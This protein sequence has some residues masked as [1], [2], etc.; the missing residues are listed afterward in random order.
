MPQPTA[1][2]SAQPDEKR[3]K[4]GGRKRGTPNRST[5]QLKEV[6]DRVFTRAF[7][8]SYEHTVGTGENARVER[9]T[10]EDALVH[11]ILT[12]QLDTK[13]LVRLLEY[14]AGAPTKRIEVEGKLTLEQLVSGKLPA[15]ADE[16]EGD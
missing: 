8:E 6:L 5:S 3:P 2:Q 10:F 14:W 4:T 13:L 9:V 12:L 16:G 1:P 11:Q 7:S 15:S